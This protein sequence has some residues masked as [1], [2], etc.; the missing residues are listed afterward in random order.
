MKWALK[1]LLEGPEAF[2]SPLKALG[3]SERLS[4]WKVFRRMFIMVLGK[5]SGTFEGQVKGTWRKSGGKGPG[6]RYFT[7]KHTILHKK[8]LFVH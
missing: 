4:Q 6:K 2:E 8:Q 7:L 3:I 5:T 1:D